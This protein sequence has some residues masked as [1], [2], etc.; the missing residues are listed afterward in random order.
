MAAG[1]AIINLPA[2]SVIDTVERFQGGERTAILISATES[3]RGY[4]LESGE[5]LPLGGLLQ[6]HPN[7]FKERLGNLEN[8]EL[9]H[10]GRHIPPRPFHLNA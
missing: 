3:D 5:F 10:V 9:N 4:L 7:S 2:C 8:S 6:G 1:L